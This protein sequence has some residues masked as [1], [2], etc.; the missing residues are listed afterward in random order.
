MSDTTTSR[1]HPDAESA[2]II[3]AALDL[4]GF[5]LAQEALRQDY[6]ASPYPHYEQFDERLG[7]VEPALAV[8]LRLLALGQPLPLEVVERALSRDFV[9]ATLALGLL[10][11]DEVTG[12]VSTAGLVVTSRLGQYFVVSANPYYPHIDPRVA[13]VYLGPE[14]MTLVDHLQRQAGSVASVGRALD[15]CCGSGIAGQSLAAIRRGLE[16]TA[17]DI[18]PLAVDA[19]TINADLN[20]VSPRYRA[21]QGDLY[22]PLGGE[23]FALIVANPPFIP[24]PEGAAFPVYGDG[25]EDGLDVLR[26]MIERLARHLRPSGRAIIYAEGIGNE[27]GPFLLDLLERAAEENLA[28]GVTILSTMTTEQML[29]TLGRMLSMQRPSRLED[30]RL[31]QESL[32]RQGVTR[33]DKMLIEARPGESGL[34]IRSIF[35]AAG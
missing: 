3:R 16:W 22:E 15:L 13:D 14:S 29:F 10:E 28:I 34:I 21:V 27:R 35:S 33:Y 30:L 18:S 7:R 8:A 11:V 4:T 25:G 17:V 26:P 5:D 32:A 1:L 23:R 24:V 19:A 9:E 2:Q 20:D 31:W 12:S 6:L